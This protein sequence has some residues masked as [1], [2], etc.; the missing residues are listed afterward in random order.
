MICTSPAIKFSKCCYQTSV[1]S[2]GMLVVIAALLGCS[3]QAD[4]QT[5][6]QDDN[7]QLTEQQP[8][9]AADLEIDVESKYVSRAS[10]P[11]HWLKPLSDQ[12][13][14]FMPPIPMEAAEADTTSEV[15]EIQVRL[16]GFAS[17]PSTEGNVSKAILKIADQLVYMKVGDVHAD[18]KLV[19]IDKRSVSLQRGRERWNVVLMNQPITNP[20]VP[21][22]SNAGNRASSGRGSTTRSSEP[23]PFPAPVPFPGDNSHFSPGSRAGGH[24]DPFPNGLPEMPEI[25]LPEIDLPEIPDINLP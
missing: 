15:A 11:E 5:L 17:V 23:S 12:D 22:R 13:N 4:E 21:Y 18:L 24:D 3:G 9:S 16:L 7:G 10:L 20:G 1:V 6:V 2:T 19:S 8:V 14:F 25:D